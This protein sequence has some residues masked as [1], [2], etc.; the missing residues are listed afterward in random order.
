MRLVARVLNFL[1]PTITTVIPAKAGIHLASGKNSGRQD[2]NALWIP[3][4]A[5]MTE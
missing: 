2:A 4:Y 5:G 1:S 3:A